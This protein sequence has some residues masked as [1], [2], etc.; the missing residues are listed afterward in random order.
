MRRIILTGPP[1]A[2]KTTLLVELE[3]NGFATVSDSAREVIAERLALGTSPRPDPKTFAFELLNRDATKYAEA[4]RS[5]EL[6]FFDRSVL[7]SLAMVQDVAPMPEEELRKRVSTYRFHSTVFILPPWEGI[8]RT[9]AERDS[10]FAHAER[11]YSRLLQWYRWCGYSINEVPRREVT[12][13]AKHVLQS[14][15]ASDA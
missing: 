13:R 1:G 5:A 6:L 11:V 10:S 14:L 2:G 4:T 15:A 12:Q 8:Y 3:R 9:D 7:E